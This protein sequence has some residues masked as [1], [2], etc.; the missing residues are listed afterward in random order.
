LLA[1]RELDPRIGNMGRANT[2][3]R[4]PREALRSRQYIDLAGRLVFE[5]I[6]KSGPDMTWKP[7]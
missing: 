4:A 1:N 2:V 3:A 7:R 5:T 6:G